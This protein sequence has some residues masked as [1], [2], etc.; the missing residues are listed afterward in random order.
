MEDSPALFCGEDPGKR[1][2]SSALAKKTGKIVTIEE[3]FDIGRLGTIVCELCGAACPVPVLRLGARS[4]YISSGPYKDLLAEVGLDTDSL[5]E[6]HALASSAFSHGGFPVRKCRQNFR[7]GALDFNMRK[8][9]QAAQYRPGLL[10]EAAFIK[11]SRTGFTDERPAVFH[12]RLKCRSFRI[13]DNQG[14]REIQSPDVA[15]KQ[16]IQL[17]LKKNRMGMQRL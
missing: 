7:P 5:V 11:K 13:A 15:G 12:E 3:H 17:V 16:E 2:A 1:F 6:G 9:E 4:D 8:I 14:H 10:Q